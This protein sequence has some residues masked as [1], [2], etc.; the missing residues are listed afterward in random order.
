MV[1]FRQSDIYDIDN[2]LP[3]DL[4]LCRNVLI[5]FERFQQQKIL[6][7]FAKALE[8]GGFLVLGKSETLLEPCCELFKTIC[9]ED[10]IHQAI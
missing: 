1:S 7:G 10:R 6:E 4:I 2:Y 8:H 3:S 9:P 5:Y